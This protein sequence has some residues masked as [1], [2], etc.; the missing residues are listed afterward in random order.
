M[1][2]YHQRLPTLIRGW[3]PKEQHS[4][5]L[6]LTVNFCTMATSGALSGQAGTA[7]VTK[8]IRGVE[9]VKMLPR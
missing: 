4:S 8:M 9:H 1:G 6:S 3:V 5:S 2:A 7:P